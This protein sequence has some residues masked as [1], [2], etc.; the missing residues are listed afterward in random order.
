M[1]RWGLDELDA[2]CFHGAARQAVGIDVTGLRKLAWADMPKVYTDASWVSSSLGCGGSGLEV[3][4]LRLLVD[5]VVEGGI[6]KQ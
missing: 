6:S 2:V 5:L 1:W 4:V 3:D